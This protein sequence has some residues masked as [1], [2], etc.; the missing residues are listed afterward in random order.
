[1]C[2]LYIHIVFVVLVFHTA[3]V[4]VSRLAI[5]TYRSPV[6]TNLWQFSGFGVVKKANDMQDEKGNI[7]SCCCTNILI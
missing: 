7:V 5:Y 3:A 6:K 2:I 1:M 4:R